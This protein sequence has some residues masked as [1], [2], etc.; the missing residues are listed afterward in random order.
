MLSLRKI[1]FVQILL[2]C[3]PIA[4]YGQDRVMTH[5]LNIKLGFIA[6]NNKLS[7]PNG[8]NGSVIG[9]SYYLFK[10]NHINSN[11]SYLLVDFNTGGLKR[12]A[13]VYG[14]SNQYVFYGGKM[15]VGKEWMFCNI[16]SCA[17]N[18]FYIGGFL[19]SE[20]EFVAVNLEDEDN[21]LIGANVFGRWTTGGDCTLR[22]RIKL[23]DVVIENLVCVPLIGGGYFPNAPYKSKNIELP[24]SYYL[25][26][27]D[28]VII[29]RLKQL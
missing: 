1:I 2:I 17:E 21:G 6:Y 16:S 18:K 25:R 4:I 23:E 28:I 7:I 5:D 15:G 24:V 19:G 13:N 20:A 8:V 29:G 10:H 9:L 22:N 12:N 3:V 11:D 27:N 14:N 26:P